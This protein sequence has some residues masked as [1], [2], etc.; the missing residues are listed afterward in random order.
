[1]FFDLNFPVV[2][3]SGATTQ[4]QIGNQKKGK[5]KQPSVAQ[6]DIVWTPAQLAK[7]ENRV[8][9]LVRCKTTIKLL[10]L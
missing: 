6:S 10:F 7:I 2:H 1:M 8:D 9:L 4:V 5:G 3:N